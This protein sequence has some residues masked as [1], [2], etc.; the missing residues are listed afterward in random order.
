MD[1]WNAHKVVSSGFVITA[2]LIVAM[3]TE[4]SH[5]VLLGTFIFLMGITMN[6][7]Q[8]GLQTLAA[9][10][11]PTHCRATGIAWMQG[12]GRFGG[13]AGTMMSA[14]LLSLQWQADS[15]LMFLSLPALVAAAATIY[16]LQR[17]KPHAL[18]VA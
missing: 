10:F 4:D 14:Q 18:T 11:Y 5:I 1:R 7:A 6:G 9:T 8:S 3:A 13:V 17:Y 16:K 2:L 15:I 12:V